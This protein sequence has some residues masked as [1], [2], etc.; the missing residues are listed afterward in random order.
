MRAD[1]LEFVSAGWDMKIRLWD[2]ETGELVTEHLIETPNNNG[3]PRM[4]GALYSPDGQS[5][6]VLRMDNK[7]GIYSSSLELIRNIPMKDRVSYGSFQYS[8]N[9]LWLG[10]GHGNGAGNIYDICS[11][12]SVWKNAKHD[13]NV[14]NV[15]F[16]PNDR[17]I[18]TGGED[19]VCYL[20][21]LNTIDPGEAADFDKLASDL[22]GDSPRDAFI[23]HQ[24]LMIDPDRAVP[25]IQ[26]AIQAAVQ[27]FFV[28]R[29][30]ADGES[31]GDKLSA[32][33]FSADVPTRIAARAS[34][35][36]LGP[37]VEAALNDSDITKEKIKAAVIA[38]MEINVIADRDNRFRR[39]VYLLAGL[40]TAAAGD[41]LDGMLKTSPSLEIKKMVFL[42]RKHRQ[43]SLQRNEK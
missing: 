19:G 15:D 39:A 7:I 28:N 18:L 22:L 14:Y 27:K 6:A 36:P 5:I 35:L 37:I 3:D 31:L 17:S 42:A 10:V 40:D 33:Y 16:S 38:Q 24:R 20:W 12:E 29:E 43:R 26:L 9:G 25:A 2:C 1:G 23:A 11:G 30:L 21:D 13:K 34:L 4:Y 41:L 8:H 32:D